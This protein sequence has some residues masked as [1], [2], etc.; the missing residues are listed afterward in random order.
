MVHTENGGELLRLSGR[1]DAE[2]VHELR[3]AMQASRA[4]HI[5]I[6][7]TE[8]A[9]LD[10]KMLPFLTVHLVVARRKGRQVTL[11]GLRDHHAQVL[12]HYGYDQDGEDELPFAD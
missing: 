12:R 6:D 7:F 9:E 10:E 5:A 4:D 11:R 8:V 1:F 2:G 3:K